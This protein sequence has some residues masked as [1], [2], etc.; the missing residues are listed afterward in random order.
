MLHSGHTLTF[1]LSGECLTLLTLILVS[2]ITWFYYLSVTFGKT[3]VHCFSCLSLPS[4]RDSLSPIPLSHSSWP[5]EPSISCEMPKGTSSK[6]FF[7][8]RN[9]V[10]ECVLEEARRPQTLQK[11]VK[12][13]LGSKVLCMPVGRRKY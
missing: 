7:R 2:Y 1:G 11:R 12:G 10:Q 8:G 5:L 13:T 6:P 4:L 9:P 3:F